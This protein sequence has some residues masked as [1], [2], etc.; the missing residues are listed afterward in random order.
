MQSQR[1]PFSTGAFNMHTTLDLCYIVEPEIEWRKMRR[2][3]SFVL[4]EVKYYTDSF[5]YVANDSVSLAKDGLI[6]KLDNYWVA[7]ILE[8]RAADEHH[9]YAR[10]YWIYLPDELPAGTVCD[11]NKLQG[12]QLYYGHNELV[13]SNYMDI[14]D[15]ISVIMPATIMDGLYWR[16]IFNYLSFWLLPAELIYECKTPANLDRMLI[17][18]TSRICGEWMY[19]ECLYYDMLMRQSELTTGKEEDSD[20]KVARPLSLKDV[21]E[22]EMQLVIDEVDKDVRVQEETPQTPEVLTLRPKVLRIN[23]Q[24]KPPAKKSRKKNTDSKPYIRLFEAAVKLDDGPTI[25]TIHDLRENVSGGEK[26]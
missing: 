8:I 23:A 17:G 15:V 13:V 16:Q 3:N 4:N 11:K 6:K 19:Y 24:A 21:E 9:V 7:W 12:C 1:F 18:C 22:K 25:W 14:I 26:I 5:V 10:V 2:Y 20:S